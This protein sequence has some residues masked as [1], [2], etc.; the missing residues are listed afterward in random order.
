M[1]EEEVGN[2][3]TRDFICA[4][5]KNYLSYAAL[6]THIKQKHDG[7]VCFKLFQAPGPIVRPR[8]E[9]KRGRPRK[10]PLNDQDPQNSGTF[11]FI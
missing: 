6:F 9:R 1:E 2:Q 7:K 11:L 10:N 4:C 3:K 5:G 8:S